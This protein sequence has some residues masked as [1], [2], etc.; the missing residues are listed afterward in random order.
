MLSAPEDLFHPAPAAF[1]SNTWQLLGADCSYYTA[2]ISAFLRY[3]RIPHQNILATRE[4]FAE[5][6]LPRVGWPVIPVLL[7]P[8]ATTLQD[9]SDM[10]DALE[11]AYPQVPTLPA[12]AAGRFLVYLMELLFDEWV[13]VPALHYRWNHDNDFAISEFGRNNDPT[14]PL[15]RQLAIGAKIAT[16]FR[17]WLGALGVNEIAAPAIETE[18]QLLLAG[19]DAHFSQHHF[20]LGPTPS[21]AD[22][23]L[24]GPFHAHLFRDPNSGALM[25]SLAPQVVAWVCRMGA[26][27]AIG[28][29]PTHTQIPDTLR[30]VLRQLCRDYVPVL[31]AQTAALQAWLT[32]HTETEI[33][34]ELGR[35]TVTLGRG[36]AHEVGT[37]RAIFSY[38][39]WMLQ[40]ALAVYA[41]ADAQ[42]R[43]TITKLAEDIGA[44]E[45]LA[46]PDMPL[47]ARH[48]FKLVRTQ[49]AV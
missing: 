37:G 40:R 24:Y 9:T 46:L 38:D 13:K 33:P 17:G 44:A 41:A 39:H 12:D 30:P 22:C 8:N 11:L 43:E 29:Q 23:A 7:G 5:H 15:E 49:E 25:K 21:L 3:K 26:V 31:L 2:K 28:E 16:R 19:L 45:L 32:S 36:T 27:P 18:Y 14:L 6:I 34:R 1:A 20:L 4:V 35:H 48:G 47:V 42:T 10:V